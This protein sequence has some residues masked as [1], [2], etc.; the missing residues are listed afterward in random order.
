[1]AMNANGRSVRRL[2]GLLLVLFAVLAAPRVVN[3]EQLIDWNAGAQIEN[4]EYT[5]SN[6]TYHIRIKGNV[7]MNGHVQVGDN[8]SVNT[9]MIV[10]IDPSVT[11][12]VTLTHTGNADVLFA[13]HD[14]CK[15]IIRGKD[16]DHRI[17]IEGNNTHTQYEMI[18]TAGTL[19]MQY[20]TVQNNHQVKESNNGVIKIN[21]GWEEKHKLGTT[22]IKNCSFINC[23]AGYATV[24]YT[25][26]EKDPRANPDN[27]PTSCAIL[28]ED[29]LI[30]RC[31][32][33][34]TDN[35][36]NSDPSQDTDPGSGW[37]GIMRFRGVWL[38]NFTMK[39][40]EI[41]ECSAEYSCAGVFWNA[42]GDPNNT[43]RQ[44][45]LTVIGCEFHGNTCKRSGGAMR[46]E[47]FCEFKDEQTK[48]Y[49]NTAGIMGGGIH[50]YGYS[51]GNLGKF[52]FNYYLTDKLY[53]HDNTAQY[54]GGIGFQL[55]QCQLEAG[56]SF[57]LHFNGAKIDNNR[58]KVKGGGVYCEDLSDPTQNYKVNIYLNRGELNGNQVYHENDK[59]EWHTWLA[60]TFYDKKGSD[61]NVINEEPYKSCGGA[62]FVYNTNIGYESS[63][64]GPLTMNDNLCLC[65]G[66]AV[67]VTGTG[68]SVNLSSLTASGNKAQDGGGLASMSPVGT[69]VANYSTLTLGDLQL[70]KCTCQWGWGGGVFMERGKLVVNDN[71]TISG[72][73]APYGGGIH[74]R[75][76]SIVTINS[77]IIE[78]NEAI[79]TSDDY[80]GIGGGIYLTQGSQ[81]TVNGS[82]TI[83]GNKA[84]KYEG[85]TSL[86][87]GLGGA[88]YCDG[89]STLNLVSA[90]IS[91]NIAENYGGG[92]CSF[93][94]T[95][96]IGKATFL[97][98]VAGING[99]GIY[100]EKGGSLEITTGAEF[101]NNIATRDGGGAICAKVNHNTAEEYITGNIKNATFRGNRAYD[102]G[103]IEL[104]GEDD[105]NSL[106]FT[107]ENNV[108]EN[109][110]AKLGGAVLVYE[111]TLNYNGGKIRWNRA[112]YVEGGPKTSFGY[113]PFSWA[114]YNADYKFSG[115][116]GGII[117]AKDGVLNISKDHPFGIYENHADIG[118]NDISTICSDAAKYKDSGSLMNTEIYYPKTLNIPNADKLNLSGFDVPVPRSAISWMEDYNAK[119]GAYAAAGTHKLSSPN[120]YS[121]MLK[122]AEGMKNLSKAMV[123]PEDPST[124]KYLHLTMGYNFV[125]VKL[126]KSG[127]KPGDTAIFRVWY[128]PTDGEYQ[129]YMDFTI[130]GKEGF[131]EVEK[132][133]A[134]TVGKWKIG[135]TNWA[136]TYTRPADQEFVLTQDDALS[137]TVKTLSFSNTKNK[138]THDAESTKVNQIEIK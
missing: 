97:G 65:R 41:K 45:K 13:V 22:T 42:M 96:K 56:S 49:N 76:G 64:A 59:K 46:I 14:N 119:D 110:V 26:N 62:V 12:P 99:G 36:P 43:K 117:V 103:A 16:N 88:I 40:V 44:P 82:V 38:G 57:N 128:K 126:K 60:K 50:M 4:A 85:G 23:S 19:D 122:T 71:A 51:A 1:M 25:S 17:I 111:A 66:G 80:G 21:P 58:A 30:D 113:Y 90:T 28:M 55:N 79:A 3:A 136:Y 78:N 9:T 81:L 67:C 132:T 35:L 135:E 70:T 37:A 134:L 95:N 48:I 2:H 72:S 53:V 68:A 54:G 98:N 31:E 129:Q 29:V 106:K 24:L 114:N 123:N 108:M 8:N 93:G 102:G 109:N 125:F 94:S 69:A 39:H 74:C 138:D 116:G 137:E 10:E 104:D 33:T 92:V 84:H 101:T 86:E 124:P 130:T 32:A 11:G 52:D 131:D 118:G 105:P 7:R 91:G 83:S 100:L 112:E 63:E 115:F 47:T 20:V 61:G 5:A 6:E 73:S 89:G 107:L 121:D 77:A 15:L 133:I 34:Y 75:E 87:R 18:G 27:T 120:R 127:L